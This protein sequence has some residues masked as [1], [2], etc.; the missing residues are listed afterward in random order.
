MQY[1]RGNPEDELDP[2]DPA[3]IA[4]LLDGAATYSPDDGTKA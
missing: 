4:V 3:P 2:E 1:L